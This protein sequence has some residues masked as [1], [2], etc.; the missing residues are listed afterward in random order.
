MGVGDEELLDPVVFLGLRRL[1]A[2]AT[3]APGTV[4]LRATDTDG[5][6]SLRVVAAS[7]VEGSTQIRSGRLK[8]QNAYGSERLALQVPATLQY[9]NGGWQTHTADGCTSLAAGRFSWSFPA[10]TAARPNNLAA[11]ES[12]AT[13]SGAAPSFVLNLNAPGAGNTGWADLSAN[14]GASASG[15]TCTTVNT[16]TGFSAAATAAGVPWLQHNWTGS[17]GNPA[18][19]VTFGVF[20]SPIIYRREDY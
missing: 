19:R 4:K 10:G 16:G 20:K 9:W 12:A 11:C 5:V 8:L 6:S 17:I 18:A 14:L 1:L 13:L 2:S 3:T 7:S 15:S